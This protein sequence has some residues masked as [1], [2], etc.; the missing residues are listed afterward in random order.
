MAERRLAQL[1]RAVMAVRVVIARHG[2]AAR[3]SLAGAAESG[4]LVLPS[5]GS[6]PNIRTAWPNRRTASSPKVCQ[7]RH[8]LPLALLCVSIMWQSLRLVCG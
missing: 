5:S 8:G 3:P 2:G 1:H 6:I 4:D 7:N